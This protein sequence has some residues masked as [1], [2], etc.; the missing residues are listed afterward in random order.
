MINGN[1]WI[2]LVGIAMAIAMCVGMHSSAVIREEPQPLTLQSVRAAEVS[3][4]GQVESI[5]SSVDVFPQVS[6]QVI[7]LQVARGDQVS[8]GQIIARVDPEDHLHRVALAKAEL[9]AAN[10]S[11]SRI[12]NGSHTLEIRAAQSRLAA[13]NVELEQARSTMKRHQYLASSG[14][15]S[16]EQLEQLSSRARTLGAQADSQ[17]ALLEKL[18]M[19]SRDEDL[20]VATANLAAA[21]ARLKLVRL[22]L[23]RTEIKS[24]IDGQIL[25]LNAHLGELIRSESP[26]PIAVIA[27]TNDLQIRCWIEDLD[28]ARITLGQRALV[29]ADGVEGSE[30][31]GTITE[32]APMISPRNVSSGQPTDRIDAWTREAWITLENTNGLVIGMRVDVRIKCEP[33]SK[34][35]EDD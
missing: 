33:L 1:V 22:D 15:V 5:H 24:P 13:L 16:S 27:N 34:P 23:E 28:V 11:L 17:Q 12:K 4:P 30:Y 21:E 7:D 32:I 26:K 3:A 9:A 20:M 2:G 14:S 6:G 25:E 31:S 19:G 35:R 8:T 10:A 18:E 29:T